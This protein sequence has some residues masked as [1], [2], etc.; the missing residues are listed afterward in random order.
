[1]LVALGQCRDTWRFDT[2]DG[3]GQD[4][5]SSITIEKDH[6]VSFQYVLKDVEGKVLETSAQEDPTVY[7]H[8]HNG[9]LPALERELAGVTAGTALNV[10]LSQPYG[11]NHPDS[12]QRI[13]LKHLH[14]KKKP[15]PGTVVVVRSKEGLRQVT[16]LKVGKFS[17]DV[18]TNHPFAGMD[19]TFEIEVL[20]VRQA[21]PEELAH[22]HAHGPGGHQH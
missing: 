16:V 1:M 7:L 5:L 21:T 17:V 9:M 14:A 22:G 12:I 13:P 4:S 11:P 18:D 15:Q 8:G 6:V 20:D 2:T 3:W 19:L 10:T